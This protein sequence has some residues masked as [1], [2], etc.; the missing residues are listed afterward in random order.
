MIIFYNVVWDLLKFCNKW[1]YNRKLANK[2]VTEK[3]WILDWEFSVQV[4]RPFRAELIV[5]LGIS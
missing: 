3:F 1:K 4:P 2:I 5:T